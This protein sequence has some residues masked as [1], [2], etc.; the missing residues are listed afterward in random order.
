MVT[1]L[2]GMVT[3]LTGMVIGM[4]TGQGCTSYKHGCR[5]GYTLTGMVTG[6][7][8][9]LTGDDH[10]VFQALFQALFQVLQA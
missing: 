7:V 6:M 2:A 9:H 1:G 8:T 10:G 5:Q 4:V 3:H